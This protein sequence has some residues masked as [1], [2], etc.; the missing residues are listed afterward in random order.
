M[1][2]RRLSGRLGLALDGEE[3]GLFLRLARGPG[4]HLGMV[5]LGQHL[6]QLDQSA[7]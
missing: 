2:E 4:E 5:L 1:S 3:L 6:S 7:D